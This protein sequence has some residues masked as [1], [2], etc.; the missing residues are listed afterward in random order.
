MLKQR[1]RIENRNEIKR[2]THG[3]RMSASKQNQNHKSIK[4]NRPKE[5]PVV[6]PSFFYLLFC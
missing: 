6:F 5:M 3:C 2:E 1:Q 4:T